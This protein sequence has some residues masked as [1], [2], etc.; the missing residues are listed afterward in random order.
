MPLNVQKVKWGHMVQAD[1]T[2][3]PAG[4]V[5]RDSVADDVFA[6]WVLGPA[7]RGGEHAGAVFRERA[8]GGGDFLGVVEVGA[9]QAEDREQAVDIDPAGVG[10]VVSEIEFVVFAREGEAR[11]DLFL[12]KSLR[13]VLGEPYQPARVRRDEERLKRLMGDEGYRNATVASHLE[14]EGDHVTIVWDIKPGSQVHVG[15][16]F[17]RGNFLTKESTI[18]T[19]AEIRPGSLLTTRAIER[20]Q[21][22]I[23][24]RPFLGTP[25]S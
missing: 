14:P 9:R 12:R 22:V 17:V 4:G 18:M 6:A 25:P 5:P 20:A 19:W 11:D 7:A 2:L 24:R 16:V 15:P 3:R 13:T 1:R 21:R 8:D 23:R 10:V